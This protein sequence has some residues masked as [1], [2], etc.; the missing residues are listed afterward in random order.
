MLEAHRRRLREDFRAAST[1]VGRLLPGPVRVASLDLAS[2]IRQV[3]PA[4]GAPLDF[5]LIEAD[6]D[7]VRVVATDRYRLALRVRSPCTA[8]PTGSSCPPG[9]WPRSARGW[10]GRTKCPSTGRRCRC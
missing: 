7:E 2:A 3:A 4:A 10:R 5:V 1:A 6:G 9:S 8:A